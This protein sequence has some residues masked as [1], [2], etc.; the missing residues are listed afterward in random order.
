LGPHDE[1]ALVVIVLGVNQ[2]PRTYPASEFQ[3]NRLP[4]LTVRSA[5]G[6]VMDDDIAASASSR[7]TP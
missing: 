6:A 3:L 5:S 2:F 7:R 1:Y 4:T